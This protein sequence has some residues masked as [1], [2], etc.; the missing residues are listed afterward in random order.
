MADRI[1]A[2][3]IWSWPGESTSIVP[4]MMGQ[5]ARGEALALA[6]PDA[7]DGSA[8]SP[9]GVREAPVSRNLSKTEIRSQVFI[10]LFHHVSISLSPHY[11]RSRS[12]TV[13]SL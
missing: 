8:F 11:Q 12:L 4:L 5:R 9:H 6:W 2:G 13:K 7:S 10:V 1:S 3:G